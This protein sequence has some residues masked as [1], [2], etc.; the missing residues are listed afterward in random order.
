M[1]KKKSC[2]AKRDEVKC[3]QRG[4]KFQPCALVLCVCRGDYEPWSPGDGGAAA[5]GAAGRFKPG[6]GTQIAEVHSEGALAPLLTEALSIV[7]SD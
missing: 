5:T 4:E 7:A 2:T 1:G 3:V 6:S